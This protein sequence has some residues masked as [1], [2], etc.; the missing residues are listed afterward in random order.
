MKHTYKKPEAVKVSF[1]LAD[2]IMDVGGGGFDW[3]TSFSNVLEI[4]EEPAVFE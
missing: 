3:V 1:E 4:E 2:K